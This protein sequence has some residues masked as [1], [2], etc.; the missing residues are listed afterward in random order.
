MYQSAH[1]FSSVIRSPRQPVSSPAL[2]FW[3]WDLTNAPVPP[4][5]LP[6]SL[7][8]RPPPHPSVHSS[9][10]VI[11][12]VPLSIPA[13]GTPS[14][15][16]TALTPS[17]LTSSAP[18]TS[19]TPPVPIPSLPLT[20]LPPIIRHFTALPSPPLS[21]GCVAECCFANGTPR[22]RRDITVGFN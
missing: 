22:E 12:C 9:R 11:P 10:S 6:P 5:S 3:S 15:L 16:I 20:Q 4:P 21:A 19:I 8:L 2:A 14:P 18:P 13:S 7:S 17:I 1:T